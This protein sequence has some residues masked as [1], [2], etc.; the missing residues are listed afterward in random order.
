MVLD[1]GVGARPDTTLELH[2]CLREFW[3]D[4]RTVGV[5]NVAERAE[6]VSGLG[7]PGLTGVIGGEHLPSV[8][9]VRLVR[10]A[11]LLRQERLERVESALQALMSPLL[12]GGVL[13]EG[14]T[15]AGGDA[16]VFRALRA[17][18]ANTVE[19][20]FLCGF[21]QGFSPRRMTAWLPRGLGWHGHPGPELLPLFT[22][23]DEAFRVVRAEGAREPHVC[24]FAACSWLASR[25]ARVVADPEGWKRGEL[26]WQPGLAVNG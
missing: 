10:A 5:D 6:L 12:A 15:D 3:P 20:A 2:R 26:R 18:H 21:A 23:W 11:N 24:F 14:T 19:V 17:P 8:G 13:V 7:E 16:G 22:S 25:D 1:V 9:A 4:L